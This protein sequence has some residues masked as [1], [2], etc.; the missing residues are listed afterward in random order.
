MC[1]I[2]IADKK[3][4][5]KSLLKKAEDHN[6]DGAGIAWIDQ[7][8]GC[9]RWIKGKNLT[10]KKIKKLIKERN[11][12]VPY[13]I[14][15]RIGTVGSVSD[16]LSHP[17]PLSENIKNQS[18]G[19]DYEG[20]LFHNGHFTKWSNNLKMTYA[21]YRENI[22]NE[23]MS[24]SR[25]ISLIANKN[26]LGLGYLQTFQ[27]QKIAVLPPKGIK[28][29][30]ADWCKV[31]KFTC[32]NHHFEDWT[33]DSCEGNTNNYQYVDDE[34]L[35]ASDEDYK[36]YMEEEDQLETYDPKQKVRDRS[37]NYCST[38][39]AIKDQDDLCR[40]L[41]SKKHKGKKNKKRKKE[42]LALKKD[43]VKEIVHKMD[44]SMYENAD[45]FDYDLKV[46]KSFT[47]NFKKFTK[48]KMPNFEVIHDKIN[49]N[50]YFNSRISAKIIENSK[51][52]DS[53]LAQEME[54][55][56]NEAFDELDELMPITRGVKYDGCYP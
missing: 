49:N 54:I 22:P 52:I 35:G 5:P 3:N 9:V 48:L 4:P 44:N 25:A 39:Q 46:L 21:S 27:D 26:K 20:V 53:E 8:E 33:Y 37:V 36:K 14:H 24:D 40:S 47:D 50:K 56:K 51:N 1:V 6:R 23:K 43:R 45:D 2:I 10:A 13:V 34:D 30:G 41:D 11:I 15:F 38:K 19:C 29:F 32:S 55:K 7:K 16:Q 28:R 31:E 17:F 12:K 42:L 18:E